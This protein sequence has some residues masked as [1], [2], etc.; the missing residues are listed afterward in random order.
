MTISSF[1][2][3]LTFACDLH[4]PS[5]SLLFLSLD[6][7]NLRYGHL[8]GE[9]LNDVTMTSSPIWFLWNSSTNMQMT[10][11]CGILNFS[12]IKHTRAEIYSMDVNRELWRKNGYCVTVTLTF[13]PRSP[14]SIGFE[15]VRE[16]TIYRKP[17]PNWCIRSAGILFT[18]SAGH[19]DTQTHRQTEV[20]I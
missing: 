1:L 19:T 5:R 11:Q 7:Q 18:R 17:R 4:R 13:D 6:G 8:F 14:N 15:L 12:L 9:N 2:W 16:A 10:Y 3:P 20:K